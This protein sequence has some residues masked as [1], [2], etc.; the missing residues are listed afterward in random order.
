MLTLKESS[1]DSIKKLIQ[2]N[3]QSILCSLY[4]NC[5]FEHIA[6]LASFQLVF[7]LI[8]KLVD[9]I[10]KITPYLLKF[11][12]LALKCTCTWQWNTFW[13]F[14]SSEFHFRFSEKKL[15]FSKLEYFVAVWPSDIALKSFFVVV[16]HLLL[17]D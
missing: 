2:C 5:S 6:L 1:E 16:K 4:N 8:L 15:L 9:I 14:E 3:P 17:L 7:Y 13:L 12:W 11:I 10:I